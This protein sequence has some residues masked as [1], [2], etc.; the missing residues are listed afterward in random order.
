MI[1]DDSAAEQQGVNLTFRDLIDEKMKILNFLCRTHLKRTLN[2]KLVGAVCKKAKKHLYNVL[3][4]RK[5]E[6]E[7]DDLL[8][9]VLNAASADKQLYIECEWIAIKRKWANYARQHFFFVVA[10]HDH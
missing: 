1:I 9:K 7:C 6:I 4:F 10:M 5:S 8:K 3:Y 2:R